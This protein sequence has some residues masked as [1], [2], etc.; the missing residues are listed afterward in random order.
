MMKCM[1]CKGKMERK[2]APFH[3]HRK[4]YNITFDEV[5]AWVCTQ[6]GEVY[7]DEAEVESIQK[8]LQILDEQ[9]KKLSAAV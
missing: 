2:T 4:G 7:F 3:I 9:T 8:V 1:F 6:C 5:P